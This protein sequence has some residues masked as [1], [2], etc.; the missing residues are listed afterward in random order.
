[1]CVAFPLD[2]EQEGLMS[3]RVQGN[4]QID[5]HT[6]RRMELTTGSPRRRSWTM[7]DK[8]R[9]VSESFSGERPVSEVALKHG[10]HRNQLYNWRRELAAAAGAESE[11]ATPFVPVRVAPPEPESPTDETCRQDD[12]NGYALEIEIG[13]ATVRLRNLA[14]SDLVRT[15]LAALSAPR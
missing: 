1:L 11:H 9:I 13:G 5:G 2:H 10:V 15:V 3:D 6:Y 14:D 4:W 12:A 7:A 8:A